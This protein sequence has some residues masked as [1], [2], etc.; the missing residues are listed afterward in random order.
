MANKSAVLAHPTKK[1]DGSQ[2]CFACKFVAY[3]SLSDDDVLQ[4]NCLAHKLTH[5]ILPSCDDAVI[6][7]SAKAA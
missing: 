7:Y 2:P 1:N 4:V 3:M 6:E 5:G